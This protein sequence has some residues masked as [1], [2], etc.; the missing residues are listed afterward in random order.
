[1]PG[2]CIGNHQRDELILLSGLQGAVRR[3]DNVTEG[4]QRLQITE[5]R[6]PHY[7]L[8][9]KESEQEQ[10]FHRYGARR[11]SA[12]EPGTGFEADGAL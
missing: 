1:M 7:P 8:R 3:K 11:W 5:R 6:L 10:A 12:K 9:I 4:M 2:R